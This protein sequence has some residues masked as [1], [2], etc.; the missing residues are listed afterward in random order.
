MPTIAEIREKYPQYNDMSD[1]DLAGA[2]HKKFYSDMP[3][4]QFNQKIGLKPGALPPIVVTEGGDEKQPPPTADDHGLARRQAMSPLEKAISPFTEWPRHTREISTEGTHQLQRGLGQLYSG[5]F[6]HGLAG[7]VGEFAAGAGNVGFGALGAT[8]APL[9]AMYR[10]IIGQP[11]EDVTGI[12]REQTEFLAQLATPGIGFPKLAAAPGVAP[13]APM[14]RPPEEVPRPNAAIS[15]ENL[16]AIP[17]VKV[18]LPRAI[19]GGPKTQ[20][21]GQLVS[22]TPGVGSRI[23]EAVHTTLPRQLEEAKNAVAAEYGAGTSTN[24]AERAGANLTDAAAAETRAATEAAAKADAEANTAWQTANAARETS[25]AERE[26]QSTQ[27]TQQAIGPE[28]HPQDMGQTVIAHTREAHNRAETRKNALYAEAAGYDGTLSDAAIGGADRHVRRD[29]LTE[30]GPNDRQVTIT[31]NLTPAAHDMR[32]SMEAFAE[33]ARQR[34]AQAQAEAIDAGG[35]AEDAAQ[36]GINLRTLETQRQELLDLERGAKTPVDRRAARRT[37]QAFDD[38]HHRAMEDHFDG[39]PGALDAYLRA[40]AANRDFRERF[41]YNKH[42]DADRLLNKIV[43]G[44]ED[45]H[46]GPVSVSEALTARNDKSGPFYTGVMEATGNHPDVQ[47]AIRSGTWNK[48]TRDARGDPLPPKDVQENVIEYLHG[49]ARDVAGRAFEPEQRDL[50]RAHADTVVDVAAQRAAATAEAKA[51]TPKP[52][53]VEDG[54]LKELADQVIAGKPHGEA[55]F[56][57]L[58]KYAQKGGDVATLARFMGRLP[59]SMK[60]DIGGAFVRELGIAPGTKQFS[61]DWFARQWDSITPQAK[62]V[63]LGNAGPHVTALNDIATIAKELKNVRGKFGNPSGSGRQ[64]AFTAMVGTIAA[65]FTHSP[66]AALS[67]AG[68]AGGSYGVARFLSNPAGASSIQKY[69][70]AVERAERDASPARMA[71]VKLTQ[72]NMANTARTLGAV[73]QSQH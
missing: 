46:T 14:I 26:A 35:T 23:G 38:W 22:Q 2:L 32:Q 34:R 30:R 19:T 37:M 8:F 11:L 59:Q 44:E 50:M 10:S 58:L 3:V 66:T 45:Q 43:R 47:Q 21:V 73:H 41:G 16:N 54:P 13:R 18:D 68:A 24:V 55:V 31:P 15:A 33:R 60:G 28:L 29:L 61:L 12:P 20:E 65:L 17:G 48:L 53:K 49:K 39:D 57:T 9:S 64:N 51:T 6:G 36:T 67:A 52:I 56:N 25:I 71:A 4:E 69:M 72:R 1:T 62:A 5:A 42:D 7:D 27:T 70:R 40:R 63:L